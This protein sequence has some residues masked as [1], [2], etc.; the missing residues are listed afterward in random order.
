ML[1]MIWKEEKQV[2]LKSLILMWEW[3]SAR[4]KTN[5][6]Q[7]CPK[8]VEV[9]HRV[10]KLAI[11]F[12][13]L[14]VPEKPPKPPDLKRWT[15]PPNDYVKINLDGAFDLG[16]KTGGWGYIIRDQAGEFVA[17][18]AGKTVH[19]RDALHSEAAACVAAIGGAIKA[20]ANRVIFE[21]DSATLVDALK[22]RSYDKATIGVLMKE[23][24]SLC[25]LNFESYSFSFSRRGC[26]RVAHELAS[27]GAKSESQD[28]IWVDAA[29]SCIVNFL[30]SDLAVSEV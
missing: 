4:N 23:A 9:C 20:G 17:A 25:M 22:T 12:S 5:A 30:T 27:L 28:S 1:A 14:K 19:L 3:W 13:F 24:R 21:S 18:G 15:R 8:P 16:S 6:G 10:E 11:E 26:N 7:L 29:P 2:Q